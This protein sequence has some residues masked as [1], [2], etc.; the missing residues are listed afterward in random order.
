MVPTLRNLDLILVSPLDIPP[1]KGDIAVFM[2][3]HSPEPVAHRIIALSGEMIHTRGDGMRRHDKGGVR[4]DQIIGKVEAI[5]RAGRRRRRHG[6][7]L[8][9]IVGSACR[10]RIG[11]RSMA[12]RLL[13]PLYSRLPRTALGAAIRILIPARS[14]LRIEA[15]SNDRFLL[16]VGRTIGSKRAETEKWL[17]HFP[18]SLVLDSRSEIP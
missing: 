3:D 11:F 7:F 8:G 5:D 4:F 18:F 12:E 14:V 6:A 9:E 10:L 1:R 15:E 2:T 13:A 17:I 16:L